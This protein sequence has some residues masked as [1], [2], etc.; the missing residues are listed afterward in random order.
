MRKPR[1]IAGGSPAD[2]I[3]GVR[4]Q[5]PPIAGGSTFT[6]DGTMDGRGAGLAPVCSAH[7]AQIPASFRSL[8]TVPGSLYGCSYIFA[9]Q[10]T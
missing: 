4:A 7:S 10:V 1:L 5:G 3:A 9:A 8:A 2:A 6:A